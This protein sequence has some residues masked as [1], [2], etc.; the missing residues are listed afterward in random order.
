MG[1]N[2]WDERLNAFGE[3]LIHYLQDAKRYSR[4]EAW[5]AVMRVDTAVWEAIR[6]TGLPAKDDWFI[7][8]SRRP[9]DL[10]LL[11]MFR[12]NLREVFRFR[13]GLRP[14]MRRGRGE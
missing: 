9:E 11:G 3:D 2:R 1:S 12:L 4:K 5:E 7:H 10:T 8:P 13:L 14:I 6:Y